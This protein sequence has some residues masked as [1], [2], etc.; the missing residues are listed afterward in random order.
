MRAVHLQGQVDPFQVVS[1]NELLPIQP[2][3]PPTSTTS[4][5]VDEEAKEDLKEELEVALRAPT[6]SP[7][8]TYGR[9]G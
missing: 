1:M 4:G 3:N 8:N 7:A 9:T 5:E 6:F 2:I